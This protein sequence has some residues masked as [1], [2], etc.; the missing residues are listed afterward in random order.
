MK[1]ILD[2]GTEISICHGVDVVSRQESELKYCIRKING[3]HLEH[4]RSIMN[5]EIRGSKWHTEHEE[6]KIILRTTPLIIT[7]QHQVKVNG[8]GYS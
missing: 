7:S 5:I 3:E 6:V 4:Q 1:G 2:D 8:K